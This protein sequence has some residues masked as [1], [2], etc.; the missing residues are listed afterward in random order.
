M[1]GVVCSFDRIRRM[2]SCSVRLASSKH[3]MVQRRVEEERKKLTHLQCLLERKRQKGT[4]LYADSS[5]LSLCGFPMAFRA[6]L[7]RRNQSAPRRSGSAS[8]RRAEPPAITSPS[9]RDDQRREN[10]QEGKRP[11]TAHGAPSPVHWSHPPILR[12]GR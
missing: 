2:D 9:T 10:Q 6:Q 4:L 11:Q 7:H 1:Y 3:A 12:L 5:Q 8:E